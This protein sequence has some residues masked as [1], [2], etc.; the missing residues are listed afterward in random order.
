MNFLSDIV[1]KI[2]THFTPQK[3]ERSPSP[4]ENFFIQKRQKLSLPSHLQ[5]ASTRHGSVLQRI[6]ITPPPIPN[7][8][9][10]LLSDVQTS[11][12]F[13]KQVVNDQDEHSKSSLSSK[14]RLLRETAKLAQE[15]LEQLKNSNI[16]PEPDRFDDAM[17][18]ISS[19]E[20]STEIPAAVLST[21]ESPPLDWDKDSPHHEESAPNPIL[22]YQQGKPV[23][24]FT[25]KE[26]EELDFV[27]STTNDNEVLVKMPEQEVLGS[28]L[29]DLVYGNELRSECINA[30]IKLLEVPE[31]V[32]IFDPITCI[33]LFK[34]PSKLRQSPAKFRRF[35]HEHKVSII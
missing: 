31:N 2:V 9:P 7:R 27:L 17:K 28:D 6:S 15:S 24:Q 34:A 22:E 35:I 23:H 14:A 25:P 8:K 10:T 13:Y 20:I 29:K 26:L 33:Q 32:Y 4:N 3:R 1:S 30:C 21:S 12:D 16:A 5:S 18:M 11:Y 19:L